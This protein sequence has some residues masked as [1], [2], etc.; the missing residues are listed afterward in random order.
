[1]GSSFSQLHSYQCSLFVLIKVTG[2]AR[3]KHTF[4]LAPDVS[5]HEANAVRPARYA[6][7]R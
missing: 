3:V 5:D 7:V 6:E 4:S 1:M 2:M